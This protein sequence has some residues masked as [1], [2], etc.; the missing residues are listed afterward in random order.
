M[1]VWL[2]MLAAV[3]LAG[4]ALTSVRAQPW[5]HPCAA[6]RADASTVTR[7]VARPATGAD[8][9]EETWEEA[10][11]RL[12]Q[13]ERQE[14]VNAASRDLF[15][16]ITQSDADKAA[17][18]IALGADVNQC[19]AFSDASRSTCVSRMLDYAVQMYRPEQDKDGGQAGLRTI[20]TLLRKGALLVDDDV[21]HNRR[22]SAALA[23]FFD[24]EAVLL[25]F[26]ESG[27][28]VTPDLLAEA[29]QYRSR[30]GYRTS[31][32][33]QLLLQKG[34]YGVRSTFAA[35]DFSPEVNRQIL[36][37]L[38]GP[39]HLLG[40]LPD[41]RGLGNIGLLHLAA[42]TGNTEVA[43]YLIRQGADIS[44][45]LSSGVNAL[46]IAWALWI[47]TWNESVWGEDYRFE[48]ASFL[49]FIRLLTLHGMSTEPVTRHYE[50]HKA[51]YEQLFVQ[52]CQHFQLPG[53]D[54]E[55]STLRDFLE[56]R[57]VRTSWKLA[58]F[59]VLNTKA[60]QLCTI[61]VN[62][63]GTLVRD[64]A[65]IRI[66]MLFLDNVLYIAG[67]E[68]KDM[69]YPVTRNGMRLRHSQILSFWKSLGLDVASDMDTAGSAGGSPAGSSDGQG[70][71][72]AEDDML[73]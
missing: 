12:E 47:Y 6:L 39:E 1:L 14:Q 41:T 71:P 66:P 19:V 51:L 30:E 27:Y 68:I 20:R 60:S 62:F 63:E 53:A 18:A 36:R 55:T 26:L 16:A 5:A 28:R 46:E 67:N 40:P 50:E 42:V 3:Q 58:R 56:S 37:H 70:M 45:T 32:P 44:Q 9:G 43:A 4:C 13:A 35:S 34:P 72:E 73:P 2:L 64:N 25:L 59:D 29:A 7:A 65:R 48:L 17:L 8:A 69:R 15:Y 21:L 61:V 10:A 23:R 22:R 38:H 52:Y 11:I 54:G 49:D 31:Y 57:F 24:K 33:L